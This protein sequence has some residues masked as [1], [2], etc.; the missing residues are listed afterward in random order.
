[1]S[2]TPS[3]ESEY[4]YYCVDCQALVSPKDKVC[5]NCG[6]DISEIIKEDEDASAEKNLPACPLCQGRTFQQE[7]TWASNWG[8]GDHVMTLLICQKCQYVLHFYDGD[9]I[10]DL[11]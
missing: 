9:S 7:Q 2:E 11:D 5:A 10:W 8:F 4:D 6:A 3:E 1:M